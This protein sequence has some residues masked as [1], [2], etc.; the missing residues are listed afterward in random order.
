MEANATYLVATQKKIQKD[1]PSE[2]NH[3]LIFMIKSL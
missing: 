3:C 2:L 1:C